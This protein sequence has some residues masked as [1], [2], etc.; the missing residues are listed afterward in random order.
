VGGYAVEANEKKRFFIMDGNAYVY[1]AFYAIDDLSTSTG[2]PTN[3]V[4]VFTNLL[5]KLLR[6]EE[7][8]YMAI[9]FDTAGPT[10]RH[11]EFAEYKADRP[12]MP[13]S[14]AQQVPTIRE[15]ISAFNIPILEQEGYEADDIIGTLA[16]KAEVEG[17]EAIIV[18]PDKDAFQLVS[19]SVKIYPCRFRGAYEDGFMFDEQAVEER[20]GVEPAKVTDF[21]GIVGDKIDNIPGVPGI[22]EKSAPK[23]LEQFGSLEE[24][25]DHVDDIGAGSRLTRTIEKQKQLLEEY[26]DQALLSKRLA[27]ID[28]HVPIRIDLEDCEVVDFD[29]DKVAD[30]FRKLE[31]RKFMAD[32]DLFLS[33]KDVRVRYRA[34]LSESDLD[35]LVDRLKHVTEFAVD[36]ETNGLDPMTSDIVGISV[37]FQPR[38]AYYIPISHRYM[39]SPEQLPPELV[40]EKLKPILSDPTIGKIGQNIKYDLQVFKRCGV[41]L[42][43]ISFDTMLASYVLNP[44]ARGHSLSDMAIDRLAYRMVPIEELIGKGRNQITMDEVDIQRATEYSCEDA[45]ITLQLKSQL[46]PELRQLDLESVLQ[47]IELPLIPVLADMEM[48]GI[49]V[50]TGYLQN[51]SD[52]LTKRLDSLTGRIYDLAGEEFNINSPKQLGQILFEKLKL[53][54]GKRTKTGYSTNEAELERLAAAGHE[55]PSSILEFRGI[56]KLKSTYVDALPQCINPETGRVH[57]SFNQAVTETGRLSSSNPNL[58]N[59]PIR[60]EEGREIRRAFIPGEEDSV[61]LAADYSQIELRMLAHLSGDDTLVEAFGKDED[62]HSRTAALIF[63]LPLHQITSD[64]RRQAKTVNFGVI[65]G[66]GAF[67][68]A[69][70]L[71]ISLSDAQQFIDSYFQTYSGV[72]SYFDQVISFARENGYVTTISGRRRRIPEIDSRNRNARE[73]AER[74]AINTPV[75]GSAADLI[76]LAMIRIAK[77]LESE[78]LKSRLLLQVHDELVFE[79]SEAELDKVSQNVRLLMEN[80]L[81]LDVPVKVDIA[82]GKNWLEAK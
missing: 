12:R 24:L 77:F 19:Q 30:L 42:S 23:L 28:V 82:V 76:K 9:A 44:S 10:F 50:D 61:L 64:M 41:E 72:K 39:G 79:V 78:N 33:L 67:R 51:L 53:P 15:V 69:R 60:T 14:L 74:T 62:I 37:S 35:D 17:I 13:D 46:E 7:P 36:T 20:Y 40:M 29:R 26:R 65:Y 3:A 8:D 6:E 21:I 49:K 58:Q 56:A 75:Q 81:P 54:P 55:L 43:G 68:L 80:A 66:M 2:I 71:G 38:E 70:E 1:S 48:A 47:E 32:F 63:G 52:T 16:K 31:F 57:T 59:I 5:L 27:T 4:F 22:G 18:T 25:L 73:F 45:D 11:K 34:I